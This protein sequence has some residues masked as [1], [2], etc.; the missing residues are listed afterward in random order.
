[1]QHAATITFIDADSKDEARAVVRYD[2]TT[3]ALCLSLKT[4]GDIDVC[5]SKDDAKRLIEALRQAAL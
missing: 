3:V 5:M 2:E 1:M 4:N